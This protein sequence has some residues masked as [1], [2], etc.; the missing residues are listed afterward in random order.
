MDIRLLVKMMFGAK[1]SGGIV[2]RTSDMFPVMLS[3][4]E[5]F[6]FNEDDIKPRR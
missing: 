5:A 2:K 1:A 6:I 4:G 3:P